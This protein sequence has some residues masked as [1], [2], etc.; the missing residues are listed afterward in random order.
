MSSFRYNENAEKLDES[1]LELFAEIN[2]EKRAATAD[3]SAP[4]HPSVGAIERLKK[5]SPLDQ[6]KTVIQHKSTSPKTR[7]PQTEELFKDVFEANNQMTGK[8]AVKEI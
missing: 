7:D 2:E 1:L 4:S 8:R 5:Q 6:V 3:H